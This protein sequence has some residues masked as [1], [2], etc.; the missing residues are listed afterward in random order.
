MRS[1]KAKMY[2]EVTKIDNIVSGGMKAY[3][4]Q[5]KEIVLCNYDG[6]I[7]AISRRCGHMNA[8][9]EMGTLEG[10][11]LTCPMHHVRFDITSGEALSSPVP[12]NLGD[13]AI[14]ESIRKYLQ[15]VG[16]LMSHIKT[17]DIKTYSVK[18][19]GESIKVEVE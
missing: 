4:V 2:V 6:K 9:L 17:C 15:Y 18:I 12:T 16:M 13:E 5:G 1:R 19:D 3:E 8:P 7:Y 10:Y 14:P 11:I